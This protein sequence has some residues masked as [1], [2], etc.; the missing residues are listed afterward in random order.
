MT[1]EKLIEELQK[2]P[3]DAL[4]YACNSDGSYRRVYSV[5]QDDQYKDDVLIAAGDV[6]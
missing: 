2:M 1:V 4:V 6:E 3:K 5:E